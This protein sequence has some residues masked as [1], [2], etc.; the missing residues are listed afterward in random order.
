ML[1]TFSNSTKTFLDKTDEV[2][3]L[4]KKIKTKEKTLFT[5]G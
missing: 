2:K 3:L 4:L 5:Q 1:R